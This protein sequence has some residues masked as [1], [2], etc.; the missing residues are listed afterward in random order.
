[1]GGNQVQTPGKIISKLYKSVAQYFILLTNTFLTRDRLA[2]RQLVHGERLRRRRCGRNGRGIGL[3][4]MRLDCSLILTFIR[5]YSK[6]VSSS[7]DSDLHESFRL[8][9]RSVQLCYLGHL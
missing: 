3:P 9:W 7:N 8:D 2:A 5:N 6:A 4:W 1:M